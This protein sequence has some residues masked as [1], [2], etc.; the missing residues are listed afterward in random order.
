[1][2]K[3]VTAYNVLISCPSDVGEYIDSMKKALGTYSGVLGKN[4]VII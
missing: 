3:T 4:Q 2:P 1:M